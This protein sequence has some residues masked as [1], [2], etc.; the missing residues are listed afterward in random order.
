MHLKVYFLV[1]NIL[2][3]FSCAI[4]KSVKI[5]QVSNFSSTDN[6]YLPGV[7]SS[8]ARDANQFSDRIIVD[9]N[10]RKQAN[11]WY[12]RGKNS[13]QV[14]D[15]FFNLYH[16]EQKK[17]SIVINLY[18]SW[19]QKYN[20]TD[21]NSKIL[22]EI[23][24]YKLDQVCLT[25]LD[26]AYTAAYHAKSL[27]PYDLNIRS[28]LIKIYL[29]RGEISNDTIYYTRAI[30]ELNNFLLVDK[31]NPYIYE[32]LAECYYVLQDWENCYKFFHKAEQ[33]LKIVSKFKCETNQ[34]KDTPPDTTRLVYYLRKQGDAKAKLYDAEDAIHYFAKA[35]EL[36]NS[37]NTRQELQ[38]ILN[39]INWDGG[40]I[41]ASETKDEI[42]MMENNSDYK[43]ARGEYLELLKKLETKKAKNEINWK[44]ASIEYNYLGRK[45]QA[46]KR[47]F[48]VIQQIR[49]SKQNN[50]LHT[51]YLKDYAA[52]C[53]SVGMEHFNENRFRL[54]YIYMNQASQIDWKHKGDCFYQLAVLSS[55]N[56]AETISNCNKALK[57]SDQL[58]E[59][60]KE[61]I[62]EML[63]VSYKRKGE[64]DMA[65]MYFQNLVNNKNIIKN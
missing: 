11:F 64:F 35:K 30:E 4:N 14:A 47:L 42:L 51:V 32:K 40:N 33:I 45:K 36:S 27:N 41:H 59:N 18:I 1:I 50:P 21:C 5:P 52:M 26:S 49:K 57:C 29:K 7:D 3:I 46:L 44:I 60:L 23:K 2:I 13:F 58:S 31:S 22:D 20:T 34:K 12:N 43:K 38:N 37:E 54:A 6:F 19:R 48:P 39:W 56:P 8:V 17:D 53:Y 24:S 25:I 62:Y 16:H 55:E 65:N 28:L 9:F 61:D 15:S 63:A 10:R